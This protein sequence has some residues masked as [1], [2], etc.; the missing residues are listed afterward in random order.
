MASQKSQRER[1]WLYWN[2]PSKSSNG[3]STSKSASIGVLETAQ[4]PFMD[5]RTSS[6]PG[7]SY[8]SLPSAYTWHFGHLHKLAQVSARWAQLVKGSPFLFGCIT[9]S[10]S[11]EQSQRLLRL[12]RHAPLDID[13]HDRVRLLGFD[14][15]PA[16]IAQA[17][18]WRTMELWGVRSED[19]K[20]ILSQPTPQLQDIYITGR[21]S[22]ETSEV[23][24]GLELPS[25]KLGQ[26]RH[27]KLEGIS[28]RC[29]Y[30]L[31]RGLTT[32]HLSEVGSQGLLSLSQLVGILRRSPA[33][34]TLILHSD[35]ILGL[36]SRIHTPIDLPLL[37][38]LSL[39]NHPLSI[40]HGLI[41]CIRIPNCTQLEVT[42]QRP[43]SQT[44]I[45]FDSATAHL[46]APLRLI[47]ITLSRIHVLSDVA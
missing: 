12:S 29:D 24:S 10:N 28:I 44:T 37:T 35:V 16:L 47:L 3:G 15:L 36:G 26:L 18:R 9:T 21:G 14:L 8:L 41:A 11:Y 1:T 6:F 13:Y 2:D 22:G 4:S 45:F 20:H 7:L 38:T 31:L 46:E 19:L 27:L 43:K 30:N 17:Q 40:T 39:L 34:A 5:F 25:E 23:T 32:L 33:L 42:C